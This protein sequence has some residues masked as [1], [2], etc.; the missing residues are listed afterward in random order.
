[1]RKP[2]FLLLFILLS[3][4]LYGQRF[5]DTI[6]FRS[7]LGLIIIPISFNGVEKQFAFDTGAQATVAFGW[8]KE[9]LKKTKKPQSSNHL[10][11]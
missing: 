11:D 6:P 1:M 10:A 8:A 3:T 5:Q 4:L 2:F 9:S 7:D